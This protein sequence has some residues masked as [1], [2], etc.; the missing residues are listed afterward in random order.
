M[1]TEEILDRLETGEMRAAVKSRGEWNAV[2]E[3]KEAILE[4]FKT[5]Q[6]IAMDGIYKGFVD[7][8]TM[9]PRTF[10]PEDGVRMVPGGSSVRRGSYVAPSV[11]IMP[12]AYV[13]T[14]AF[15]DEGSMVDSHVLVGSCAQ[16]G[17]RV[18][19]SAGVQLGGVLEPVGMKPVIIEDD[20]FVGA[21]CVIVEG[22]VVRKG[23]VLAPGVILSRSVPVY[24]LVE[25][26]L[27]ERG[28]DIPEFSVVIPGTR[29]LRQAFA[30][31][32]QLSAY[33]AVI[34]KIRDAS[35][36]ASLELEAML[37]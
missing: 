30:V 37:R 6:N 12:P 18:H 36:D 32:E 19:L 29:P 8:H 9:P 2:K 20:C 22:M 4:A 15:V 33:C 10:R 11:I 35:S 14:G 17:K 27:M 21:G 24:N 23:A 31:S 13:N 1:K 26:R 3:V 16:V 5:G 28:E 7:K 34:V 25:E